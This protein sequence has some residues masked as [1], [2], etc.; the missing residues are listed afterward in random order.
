MPTQTQVQQRRNESLIHY[1]CTYYRLR[2]FRGVLFRPLGV[3]WACLLDQKSMSALVRASYLLLFVLR[4]HE[5]ETERKKKKARD[6]EKNRGL[7]SLDT[8]P[9]RL[10]CGHQIINTVSCR[11]AFAPIEIIPILSSYMQNTLQTHWQKSFYLASRITPTR[12]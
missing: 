1:N 5:P 8:V 2:T 3:P 11:L 6:G 12:T 9:F 10:I 7:E 4:Q